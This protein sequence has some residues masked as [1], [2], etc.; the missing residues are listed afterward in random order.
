MAKNEHFIM[1]GVKFQKSFKPYN[2]MLI[3]ILFGPGKRKNNEKNR[4]LIMTLG[5][6]VVKIR[7]IAIERQNR[8]QLKAHGLKTREKWQ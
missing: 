7:K 4:V 6:H 8:A 1:T 5:R 2:K 3:R